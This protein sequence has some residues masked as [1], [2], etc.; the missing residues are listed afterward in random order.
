MPDWHSWFGWSWHLG[1]GEPW[2]VPSPKPRGRGSAFVLGFTPVGPR[3]RCP[4]PPPQEA[5]L[6]F[7][8]APGARSLT[9]PVPT[10][11]CPQTQKP[12]PSAPPPSD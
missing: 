6:L 11:F 5:H 4:P 3:L 1:R 7:V 12:R 2:G 10:L 9:S 8:P